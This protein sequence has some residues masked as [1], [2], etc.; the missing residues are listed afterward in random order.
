MSQLLYVPEFFDPF[1]LL[2]ADIQF[3]LK[4]TISAL[5]HRFKIRRPI[6]HLIDI[7]LSYIIRE[8]ILL[9]VIDHYQ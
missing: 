1:V 3:I 6:I 7:V 5:F 2:T 8:K 9:D 4:L